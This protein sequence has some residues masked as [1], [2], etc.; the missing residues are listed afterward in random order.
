MV[1]ASTKRNLRNAFHDRN[2]SAR[3]VA[4]ARER[5]HSSCLRTNATRAGTRL[6][7]SKEL[8]KRRRERGDPTNQGSP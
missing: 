8:C 7:A 6:S 3:S 4:L 2:A 1:E 5:L